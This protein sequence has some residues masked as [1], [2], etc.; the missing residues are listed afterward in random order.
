MEAFS[1]ENCLMRALNGDLYM[2]AGPVLHIDI[3]R[4]ADAPKVDGGL[5]RFITHESLKAW[6]IAELRGL[7]VEQ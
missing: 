4:G 1:E 6:N 5:F 3:N 7:E 2:C